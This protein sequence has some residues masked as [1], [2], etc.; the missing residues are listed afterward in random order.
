MSDHDCLH[1][2]EIERLI[3]WV[4]GN[5]KPGLRDDVTTMKGQLSSIET[6]MG[7]LATTVSA[8]VKFQVETKTRDR[9]RLNTWQRASIIISAILGSA[10]VIATLL[11][12]LV[13]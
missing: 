10:G 13:A 11:V 4:D 2:G 9:I 8:L 6:I 7:G 5:G 3:Q 12:K 1:E